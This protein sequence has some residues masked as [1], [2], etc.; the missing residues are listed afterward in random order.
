[1]RQRARRAKLVDVAVDTL[2]CAATSRTLRKPCSTGAANGLQN[3][4]RKILNAIHRVENRQYVPITYEGITPQP[5][6]APFVLLDVLS[7]ER[8]VPIRK[9]PVP[10]CRPL[11]RISTS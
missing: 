9:C 1:M 6:S 10:W 4:A 11:K 5:L 7:D 2:S 3:L 8:Y